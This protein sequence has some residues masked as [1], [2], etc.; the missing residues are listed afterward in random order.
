MQAP[1]NATYTVLDHTADTGFIL[2]GDSAEAV[3][4]CAVEALFAVMG[5]PTQPGPSAFTEVTAQGASCE[6][7]L[8]NLISDLIFRFEVRGEHWQQ[9]ETVT[10]TQGAEG[11]AVSVS[12]AVRWVDRGI[13]QGLTEVKAPTYHGLAWREV[14]AGLVAARVILDL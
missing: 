12:G 7:A 1:F 6:D 14:R 2:Q 3:F 13:T 4:A 11:V 8:F 10:V 9:V 5:A